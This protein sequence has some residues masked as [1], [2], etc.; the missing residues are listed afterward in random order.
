MTLGKAVEVAAV[1]GLFVMKTDPTT[2]KA[3]VPLKLLRV[4]SGTAAKSLPDGIM[5]VGVVDESRT[6][7]WHG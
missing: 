2:E 6:R 3:F 5:S 1:V 4:S 7:G